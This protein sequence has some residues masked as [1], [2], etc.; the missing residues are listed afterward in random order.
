MRRHIANRTIEISGQDL[1]D[2]QLVVDENLV[3]D[4]GAAAARRV[5]AARLTRSGRPWSKAR[6]EARNAEPT[7]E[8]L[9]VIRERFGRGWNNTDAIHAAITAAGLKEVK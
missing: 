6:K 5:E 1:A 7:Q 2:M 3:R 8:M 4:L 9:K